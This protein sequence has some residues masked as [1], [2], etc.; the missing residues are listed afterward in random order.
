MHLLVIELLSFTFYLVM[1]Q[2]M[3]VFLL[4][5]KKELCKQTEHDALWGF[6]HAKITSA[7]VALGGELMLATLRWL[8][9]VMPASKQKLRS[10]LLY[11]L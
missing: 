3:S 7:T 10:L 6:L 2:M 4:Q 1:S 9:V 5:L 11:K 8:S